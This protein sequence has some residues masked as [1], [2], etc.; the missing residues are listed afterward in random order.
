MAVELIEIHQVHE[1]QAVVE[2][3][4][5]AQRLRHAVAVILRLLVVLN[6]TAQKHI[7]DF[8]HAENADAGGFQLIQQH[9]FRRRNRIVVPI[10]SAREMAWTPYER[11]RNDSPNFVRSTK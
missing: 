2:F 4:Q 3:V 7:E 1:D 11:T 9:A 6:A 8:S 5:C 10:W